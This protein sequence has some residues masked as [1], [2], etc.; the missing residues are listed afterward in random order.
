MRLGFLEI[1]AVSISAE[2]VSK[3]SYFLLTNLR[4]ISI[5]ANRECCV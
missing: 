1:K 2:D 4:L 5:V 3:L